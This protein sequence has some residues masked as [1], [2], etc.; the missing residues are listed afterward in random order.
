MRMLQYK[1]AG[2]ALALSPLHGVGPDDLKIKGLLTRVA[3][4]GVEGYFLGG[5]NLP[6]WMLG[7]SGAA[8][9][10]DVSGTLVI[11][12]WLFMLGINGYWSLTSGTGFST[13]VQNRRL[14][15]RLNEITAEQVQSV[16]ARY[17]G[18]DKLSV[19]ILRPLPL[20]P[21]RKPRQP[22]VQTRH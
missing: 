1:S 3:A 18:D 21:N 15:E 8:A 7:L 22:A 5:R 16:A 9:N 11:V 20:D 6:G 17:F 4:G 12:S 19:G 10:I 13:Y 2:A 14:M